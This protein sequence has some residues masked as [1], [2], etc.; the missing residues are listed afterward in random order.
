MRVSTTMF[1]LARRSLFALFLTFFAVAAVQAQS[2]ESKPTRQAPPATPTTQTENPASERPQSGVSGA[3]WEGPNAGVRFTWDPEIWTVEQE[4]LEPGYDGL[5]IGTPDS[6]IFVEAYD[7]FEGDAEA[8]LDAS[9]Q[10][11]RDREGVSE[12]VEL[13]GRPL[14]ATGERQGPSRLLGVVAATPDERVYRGIEY[15]ECRTLISGTS[16]LELTWQ[17]SAA[18]VNQEFP[19]AEALLASVEMP[20]MDEAPGFPVAPPSLDPN[21]AWHHATSSFP[22]SARAK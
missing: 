13:E 20:G 6:T 17:T 19:L 10:E 18:A 16:V 8:C 22:E 5:Q 1:R 4:S 11:I 7:G 9:E 3:S 2:Q 12:V 14:P 21:T 15:V